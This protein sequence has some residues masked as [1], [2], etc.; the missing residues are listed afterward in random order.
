[1]AFTSEDPMTQVRTEHRV[2]E[3]A[4][5]IMRRAG[6]RDTMVIQILGEVR[7]RR[8]GTYVYPSSSDRQPQVDVR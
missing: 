5:S 6:M 3:D 4:V 7:Q 1:V 8:V 2:L